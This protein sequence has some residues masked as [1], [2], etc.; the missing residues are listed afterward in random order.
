V[1][2]L[3]AVR[4]GELRGNLGPTL[5][6]AAAAWVTGAENGSIRN[7]SGDRYKPS[8]VRGYE[9]ALR[10]RLV[11]ELGGVRLGDLRRADVQALVVSGRWWSLPLS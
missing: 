6:E 1:D 4:R 8:A 10:L 2:A 7:R 5:G 11:P 9:Q 3:A